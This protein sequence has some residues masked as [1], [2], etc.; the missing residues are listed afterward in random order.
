M[1]FYAY[2]GKHQT[3]LIN[4]SLVFDM[5]VFQR[6][7]FSRKDLVKTFRK[8]INRPETNTANINALTFS[9]FRFFSGT[10]NEALS[11]ELKLLNDSSHNMKYILLSNTI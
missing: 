3:I 10:L 4:Y 1:V 9:I 8:K 6:I 11:D 7:L 5:F 2:L